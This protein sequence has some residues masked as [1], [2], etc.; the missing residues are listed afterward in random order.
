[1]HF[2]EIWKNDTK[3]RHFKGVLGPQNGKILYDISVAIRNQIFQKN[4]K[5]VWFVMVFAPIKMSQ[6][7]AKNVF[8]LSEGAANIA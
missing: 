6:F 8:F 1:M 3:M 4:H 2:L 5:N 7:L